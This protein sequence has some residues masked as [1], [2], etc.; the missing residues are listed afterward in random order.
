MQW[1]NYK[2]RYAV[3]QLKVEIIMQWRNYKWRC[4]DSKK[5]A[6]AVARRSVSCSDA[7]RFELGLRV[8]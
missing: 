4:E 8:T 7:L 3:A 5:R 6:S 2:W 1:R